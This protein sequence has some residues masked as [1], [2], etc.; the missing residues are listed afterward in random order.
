MRFFYYYSGSFFVLNNI[1][2][3]YGYVKGTEGVREGGDEDN[4]P[5]RRETRRL[6]LWYVFFF[7][8]C[9]FSILTNVSRLYSTGYVIERAG[10]TKTGP[11]DAKRAV[12]TL[13]EVFFFSLRVFQIL[14]NVLYLL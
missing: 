7:F 4:G 14:T 11:N 1:Y 9:I 12:W 8:F 6:G 13:G 2:S 10:M 3:V 5:K